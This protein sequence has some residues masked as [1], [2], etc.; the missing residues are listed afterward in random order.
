MV[1]TED[2]RSTYVL[3]VDRV[4]APLSGAIARESSGVSLVRD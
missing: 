4:P 1:P 2:G 3:K